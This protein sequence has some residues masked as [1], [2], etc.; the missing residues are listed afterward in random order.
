MAAGDTTGLRG[1]I[2]TPDQVRE[3]LRRYEEAGVDQVIFVLQAGRNRHEHIMESLEVF[4]REVLPEFL[5]RDEAAVGDKAARL[6]PSSPPRWPARSTSRATWATTASPPSLGSGPP[7]AGSEEMRRGC[8]RFADDRAAGSATPSWHRRLTR[9]AG[10]PSAPVRPSRTAP[11][12]GP[13]RLVA[14]AGLRSS[15]RLSRP[16]P[17]AS[18]RGHAD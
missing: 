10:P 8:D 3:Y 11:P 6:A 15:S 16:E 1:A 17:N 18:P 9:P 5:D 12:S 4:G 14:P 7:R 13:P 2:G